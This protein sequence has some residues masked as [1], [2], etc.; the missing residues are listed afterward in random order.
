MSSPTFETMVGELAKSYPAI[1]NLVASVGFFIGIIFIVASLFQLRHVGE[2]RSATQGNHE[3]TAPLF[4]ILIGSA[5]IYIPTFLQA[6]ALTLWGENE[7]LDYPNSTITWS[8]GNSSLMVVLL[9]TIRL[10]GL[11]SFIRGWIILKRSTEQGGHG[12]GFLGK[13]LAH[14]I[15]GIFCWHIAAFTN[16]V[17]AT[18]GM[19]K[20]FTI[21]GL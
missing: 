4:G 19:S 21:A 8:G 18:F 12:Q 1:A 7:L 5:L 3:F 10:V 15:G 16:M 2:S 11:I 17:A 14:I 9:N 20:I 6:T 13:A